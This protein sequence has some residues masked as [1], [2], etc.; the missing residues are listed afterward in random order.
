MFNGLCLPF[1]LGERLSELRLQGSLGQWKIKR[2]EET[3]P[4]DTRAIH[5][6]GGN[7]KGKQG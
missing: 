5:A 2:M 6:Y 3:G 1:S 4:P 7:V